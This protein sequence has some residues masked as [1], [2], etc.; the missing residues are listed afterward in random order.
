MKRTLSI[1]GTAVIVAIGAVTVSQAQGRPNTQGAVVR[2]DCGPQRGPGDPQG[3]RP[4]RAGQPGAAM[5]TMRGRGIGAGRGIGP[6][7]GMG[8]GG[9]GRM[10]GRG[11]ALC[12]L[13]LTAEQQAQIKALREESRREIEAI[14]TPEQVA[15]L[16]TRRGGK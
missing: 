4:G 10:G 5:N 16:K 9:P 1:V 12:G 11:F 3:L 8:R 14:L 6:G 15:K 2:E 7:R 13:D